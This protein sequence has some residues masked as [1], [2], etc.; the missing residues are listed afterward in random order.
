MTKAK[1]RRNADLL[2]E[3]WQ[4]SGLV[5]MT[6]RKVGRK[7]TQVER[8]ATGDHYRFAN[9]DWREMVRLTAARMRRNGVRFNGRKLERI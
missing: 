4:G 2:V 1:R 3:L 8:T 6:V 5:P 9:D 7:W